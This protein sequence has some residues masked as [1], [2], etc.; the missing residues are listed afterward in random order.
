[1]KILDSVR[2]RAASNHAD[3]AESGADGSFPI[4]RYDR[5]DAKKISEMLPGLSQEQLA[6]VEEH[7]RAH[8]AR[9]PVLDRLRYLRQAEPFEGYD[10]LPSPGVKQALGSADPSTIRTVRDY[11]RKFAHRPEILAETARLLER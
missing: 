8:D 2:R 9:A 5:L 7:E 1:M 4:S 10:E 3:T 11:E 6:T